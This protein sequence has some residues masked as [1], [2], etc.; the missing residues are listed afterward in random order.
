VLFNSGHYDNFA[1]KL[2]L[3]LKYRG[4]DVDNRTMPVQDVA[5]ALDGLNRLFSVIAAQQLPGGVPMV[6]LV[7]S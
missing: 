4:D 3:S 6:R 7:D 2:K 1:E 5:R